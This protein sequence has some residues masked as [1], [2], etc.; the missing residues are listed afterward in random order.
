MTATAVAIGEG[1]LLSR[2][3]HRAKVDP[4]LLGFGSSLEGCRPV[5]H[6]LEPSYVYGLGVVNSGGWLLQNPLFGGY[7]AV[8]AYLPAKK[9]AIAVAVTFGEGA[10]D[11]EGN[12]RY[13]NASQRLFATIGA[14]LAPDDAPPRPR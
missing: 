4:V 5:C 6:T 13:G 9:I 12:Y 1:T 11:E 10:F 7:G 2:A 3:S 14:F 8:A